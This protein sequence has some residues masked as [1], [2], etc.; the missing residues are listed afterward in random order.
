MASGRVCVHVP[1]GDRELALGAKTI[2]VE[3]SLS[4]LY[5]GENCRSETQSSSP[6]R[7]W[8]H[9]ADRSPERL[10]WSPRE[11]V[12]LLSHLEALSARIFCKLGNEPWEKAVLTV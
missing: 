9:R 2:L 8:C 3:A 7:P 11:H 5:S 1:T 12:T 4:P 10:R 6:E